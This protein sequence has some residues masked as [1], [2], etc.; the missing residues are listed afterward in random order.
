MTKK[1]FFTMVILL[2]TVL[3]TF[4]IDD[5][6]YEVLDNEIKR[7]FAALQK[8]D[9]NLYFLEY[10]IESAKAY[11]INASFG[12][13]TNCFENK[14]AHCT[15]A[16]R[17]GN[18]EFDN[19]HLIKGEQQKTFTRSFLLPVN[20]NEGIQQQ[21]WRNVSQL[22]EQVKSD[23]TQL[24]NKLKAQQKDIHNDFSKETTYNYF[25]PLDDIEF[26]QAEQQKWKN[27]L[28]KYSEPFKESDKITV[29]NTGLV[30]WFKRMYYLNSD[31]SRIVQNSRNTSFSINGSIKSDDGN[32]TPF[33]KNFIAQSINDLPNDEALM[34]ASVMVKDMLLKLNEAPVADPYAGP[35][36]MAPEAAGV[37]FHEIFG[38]RLEGHRLKDE[39]D[40][41]TFK[42][43]LNKNV[44]PK[45]FSIYFDPTIQF[46]NDTF[47][48][49]YYLYDDEGVKARRVDIVENGTLKTFLMNRTP[50]PGL[51]Q[52]NGHGR[53]SAGRSTVSRQSNMFIE[54]NKPVLED[55]LKSIMLKECK[56]Q[57]KDYGYYVKS[58][59][60]GFTNGGRYTPNA[61]NVT[62][63][64]VYR[65]YVDGRPDEL[66][67]GVNFIGTPLAMF[68]EIAAAGN[69]KDIFNGF[70]GA[71]SGWVPVATVSPSI[72]IK[73]VETQR[74]A[75]KFAQPIILPAPQ[76]IN[77]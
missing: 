75:L 70:C 29:G 44:L 46:F 21:L 43:M 72:Y 13:I 66:V 37:F 7:E 3:K 77:E 35:V 2:F 36:I 45:S 18:H 31:G 61:F 69:T 4:A 10:R 22:Y 76:A 60:G 42:T 56:K 54:S 24:K 51:S 26:S 63:T 20:S 16:M 1:L 50:V 11:Y 73:K 17:Y 33:Y 59:S 49:G 14:N 74:K 15:I 9:S 41:N 58:V 6:F 19:T 52:S 28:E 55:K 38:H 23:Y 5:E 53:A 71:E 39:N 57:K 25:E 27:R 65:V 34:E 47:L 8:V 62:P 30:Y 40:G 32:D 64:E 12:Y 48:N 68:S 67:R